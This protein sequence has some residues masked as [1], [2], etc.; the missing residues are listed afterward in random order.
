MG[1]ACV[2]NNPIFA[3]QDGLPNVAGAVILQVEAGSPAAEAGLAPQDIIIAADDEG[4]VDESTLYRI[5]SRRKPGDTLRLTVL[6]GDESREIAL[7]L[8]VFPNSPQ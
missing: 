2:Y 6:R 5:L 8:G 4:L 3:A 1:W 7:A